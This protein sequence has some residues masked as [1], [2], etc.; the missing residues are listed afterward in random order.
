MFEDLLKEIEATKEE[1]RP[2]AGQATPSSQ[3]KVQWVQ[4]VAHRVCGGCR[5]F[6]GAAL[7]NADKS[8]DYAASVGS[9]GK[10]ERAG[11]L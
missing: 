8:P 10:Y 6:T 4:L 1:R 2:A 5:H 3:A 9:C 11:E 7:C